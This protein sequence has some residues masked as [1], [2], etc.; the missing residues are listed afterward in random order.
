MP[1]LPDTPDDPR[2]DPRDDPPHEPADEADRP[3]PTDAA[4]RYARQRLFAPL[5]R[6]GDR[7]LRRRSVLVVGCGAL[8]THVAA[9]LARAGVGSLRLVDRDLVEWSNLHRQ[10]EF[11]E[12]DARQRRPKAAALAAHLAEAS[13]LIKLEAVVEELNAGT[14][15][16]LAAG[17]DLLVD[18]T[19]NLPARFLIND[20]SLELGLPWVYGGAVGEEAHAQ[21][22]LPGRGPCLRC[23]LPQP[24]PPGSLATCDTAGVIGPAPAAAASYQAA[25]ALRLLASSAAECHA[26]AGV[27]VRLRLWNLEATTSRVPRDPECPACAGGERP[28][29]AGELGEE[30]RRLCGRRA[31][32]VLP[33]QR[34]GAPLALDL[35]ALATRLAGAGAVT[36]SA[37]LV[38]FAPADR[39]AELV[40]FADGRAF[41]EGVTDPARARALYDRYVGQ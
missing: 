12:E 36:R 14:A 7:R 23:I 4:D 29:L 28:F 1:D 15:R 41:V 2:D 38:R 17:V 30:V 25:M 18:A 9:L 13:S 32:Q 33:A 27:W 31:V 3:D 34:E 20:L 11:T 24:P 22:F 40:V 5:G 37:V 8:G 26:L 19:D 21:L 10:V 6:D 35:A 39:E 16:R